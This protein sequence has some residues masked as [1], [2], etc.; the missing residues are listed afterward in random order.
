MFHRSTKPMAVL[1]QQSREQLGQHCIARNCC[2]LLVQ[3]AMRDCGI[4]PRAMTRKLFRA[5]TYVA[6]AIPHRRTTAF[7]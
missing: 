5:T 3:R 7:I 2:N 6:G 1:S 4:R